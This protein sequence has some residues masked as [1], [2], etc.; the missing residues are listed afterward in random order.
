[1]ESLELMTLT[2]I[3][4][5]ARDRFF[6]KE[7]ISSPSEK[8]KRKSKHCAIDGCYSFAKGGGLCTSHGGK[9]VYTK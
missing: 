9:Y 4:I 7:I 3:T 5:D 2:Y 6:E 1:M 8:R